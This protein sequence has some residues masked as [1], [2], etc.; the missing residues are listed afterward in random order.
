MTE[1]ERV[2]ALLG[3]AAVEA[4]QKLADDAPPLTPEQ[5]DQ[6]AVLFRPAR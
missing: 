1:Y 5:R 6:L 2:I 3:S 4:A